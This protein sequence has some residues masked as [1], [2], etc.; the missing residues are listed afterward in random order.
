[1][2]EVYL[3]EPAAHLVGVE[4]V[5]NVLVDRREVVEEIYPDRSGALVGARQHVY[6]EADSHQQEG[7]ITGANITPRQSGPC[8]AVIRSVG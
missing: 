6:V 7:L 5:E 4:A 1:M 2:N 3:R 8:D